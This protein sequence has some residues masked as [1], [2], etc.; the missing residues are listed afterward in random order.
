MRGVGNSSGRGRQEVRCPKCK[1]L[2]GIVTPS[3]GGAQV[4]LRCP[5]CKKNT[6]VWV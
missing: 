3:D 4:E 5:R 2:L 6:V 1:K